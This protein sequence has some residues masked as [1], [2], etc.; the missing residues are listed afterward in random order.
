MYLSIEQNVN[1]VAHIVTHDGVPTLEQLQ[2][3]VS[4]RMGGWIERVASMPSRERDGVILSV[5]VNEDPEPS[6][7]IFVTVMPNMSLDTNLV[8]RG[9]LA[10]TACESESGEEIAMIASEV[11]QCEIVAGERRYV[12]PDGTH[13]HAVEVSVLRLFVVPVS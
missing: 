9:P 8:I 6:Q 5:F 2:D 12:Y 10:I 7:P 4:Q 1:G 11:A 13:E 3:I